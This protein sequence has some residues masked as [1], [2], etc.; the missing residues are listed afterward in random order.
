MD[1]TFLE[2]EAFF[3]QNQDLA[4]GESEND[5]DLGFLQ[6]SQP[7]QAT[8]LNLGCDISQPKITKPN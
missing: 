6:L 5:Q 2:N 8:N 4:Q 3:R 1:V 7:I